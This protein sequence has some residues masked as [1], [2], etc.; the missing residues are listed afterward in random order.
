MLVV[1]CFSITHPK[2]FL[3]RAV[4]LYILL[5]ILFIFDLVNPEPGKPLRIPGVAHLYASD[6]R[7]PG[8]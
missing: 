6:S 1:P 8:P 2:W 4:D 5:V 7:N 3:F